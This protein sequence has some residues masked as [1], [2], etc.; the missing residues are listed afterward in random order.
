[1]T[2][3]QLWWMTLAAGVLVAAVV[4]LLLAIILRAARRI[5]G[6]LSELWIV[7]QSVANNTAHVDL[8][9]RSAV[10]AEEA[11]ASLELSSQYAQHLR[12]RR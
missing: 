6:T 10:V 2:A 1:M 8:L 4:G 11:L 12:S 5:A 9:R 3:M 7:G